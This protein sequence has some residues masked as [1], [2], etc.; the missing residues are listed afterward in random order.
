MKESARAAAGTT[1]ESMGFHHTVPRFLLARWASREGKVERFD[2]RTGAVTLENPVDIG[3]IEGFN[4]M[5]APDGTDDPWLESL[6]LG[7]LDTNAARYLRQLEQVQ[8][9]RS[10]LRRLRKEG[11]HLNHLLA[12]RHNVALAMFVAAQAVRTEAWRDAVKLSTAADIKETVETKV[13]REL[14]SATDEAEIERL[15]SMLGLRFLV[16]DTP[17]NLVPH[18]SGHFAYRLGQLLYE[19]YTWS[20]HR[21]EQPLLVIGDEPVVLVSGKDSAS[22]GSFAQVA[23]RARALSI[24]ARLEEMVERAVEVVAGADRIFMPI[25]PWRALVLTSHEHLS[26]AGRYDPPA[27]FGALLNALVARASTRWLVASPGTGGLILRATR[28]AA[29]D[30]SPATGVAA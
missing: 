10:H 17:T 15:R 11:W 22:T 2:R 23:V 12:P 20:V 27:T 19:R 9:S 8:P 25:D 6:F 7:G 29:A 4:T 5:V 14:A 3:R 21:F 13:R 30:A 16:A 1:L 28:I 18:L 26:L 24:Y